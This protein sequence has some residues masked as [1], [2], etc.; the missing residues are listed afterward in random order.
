MRETDCAWNARSE[1]GSGNE[2]QIGD[3][4]AGRALHM[5][6]VCTFGA[7]DPAMDM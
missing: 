7:D 6:R 1:R 4:T 5:R 3:R 2:F